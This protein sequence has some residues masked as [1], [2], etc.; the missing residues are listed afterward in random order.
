MEKT[1][2]LFVHLTSS[3]RDRVS[4]QL[5]YAACKAHISRRAHRK[6]RQKQKKQEDDTGS[7]QAPDSARSLFLLPLE[8][9]GNSDP[10]NSHMITVSPIVNQAVSF[11]RFHLNRCWSPSYMAYFQDNSPGNCP[12]LGTS[13]TIGTMAAEWIWSFF[14]AD[15]GTFWSAV[16]SILP[17][18]IRFVPSERAQELH[19]VSLELKAR[20]LAGLRETL[21]NKPLNSQPSMT[22]IY[23][24]KALF[25][26][27]TTSGDTH[28]A[29]VHARLLF[30]LTNQLPITE[31]QGGEDVLGIALWGDSLS[32]LFQLRRPIFNYLSWMPQIVATTW[33]SAES[34]LPNLRGGHVPVPEC[35]VSP[36]LQEAFSHIRRV[37]NIGKIPM[38]PDNDEHLRRARL[39]F[40]WV[41]TKSEYHISRLLDLYFDL[42]E[43]EN[44]NEL[45]EGGR[46]T[47][48]ALALALLYVFQKSF[49]DTSQSGCIDVH[50]SAT[51]IL[52]A[53]LTRIQS[54]FSSCSPTER[55]MYKDAHFWILFI[56]S[57]CEEHLRY[58][59]SQGNDRNGGWFHQH[60]AEQALGNRLISWGDA[61]VVLGRFVVN[62]FLTPPAQ[63]W[64]E[65]N[66]R[67]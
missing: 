26:E 15:V 18:M 32:A 45:S 13:S 42:L 34:S 63:E 6:R 8:I 14:V 31:C 37:L 35:V 20:I 53:L 4:Q 22:L 16:A 65:Q 66:C 50:D 36:Q 58:Q 57:F 3:P 25:R 46:H 27:A 11:V 30:W 29:C 33:N 9:R 1:D 59:Y 54:A 62:D 23:Q 39:I 64:Y 60:L 38:P 12:I 56:G 55:I 24:V 41:T 19:R 7:S 28:S 49:S 2:Y 67:C 17:L 51:I 61:R 48:A 44:L 40:H 21:Q 47:E 43:I 10:F 52:P 5:Q